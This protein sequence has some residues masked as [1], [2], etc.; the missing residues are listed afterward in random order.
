VEG[1]TRE[2]SALER[3]LERFRREQRIP[4]S[5]TLSEL[6]ETYLAQH[7][8][9]QVTIKKLR[10]LVGKATA[11]FG[12]CW[13]GESWAELEALAEAIGPRYGSK[14][15]S[16]RARAGTARFPFRASAAGN[17]SKPWHRASARQHDWRVVA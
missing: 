4:R 12:E 15:S 3:E 8:V 17:G 11:A 2:S 10:W 6:M 1:S 16:A 13:I 7:D 14:A 9:Q 5:L